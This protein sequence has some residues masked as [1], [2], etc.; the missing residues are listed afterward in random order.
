MSRWVAPGIGVLAAVWLL[1]IAT[2][3]F[4]WTPL[5]ALLYAGAS[6]ICHQLPER[7]FHLDGAQL[8]VCGRCF[9]LYAGGTLG[10]LGGVLA[11]GGRNRVRLKADTTK[12]DTT[13]ADTTKAVTTGAATA[14]AGAGQ[15]GATKV[16]GTRSRM[17]LMTGVAAVPTAMTV[18]GEWLLGWS[19]SN[20]VRAFAAVPFG[21][22]VAI[23]VMNAVATLH[24]DSCAPPRPIGS[25]QSPTST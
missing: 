18:V 1:L 8:P 15:A 5:A 17:W 23:V 9:G 22:A 24:Y 14:C 13:K 16:P 21:C 4:L 25:N 19:L 6:L 10:S 2:A 3:P 12:A 11:F 7:S 20:A